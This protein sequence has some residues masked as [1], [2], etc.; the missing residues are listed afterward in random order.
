MTPVGTPLNRPRGNR[1]LL[2][3]EIGRRLRLARK[4]AH[5]SLVRAAELLEISRSMLDRIELGQ[6][7][8]SVHLAREMARLYRIDDPDDELLNLV[9]SSRIK[10]WWTQYGIANYDYIAL[11]DG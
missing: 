3:R 8:V 6:G 1:M 2:R 7:P 4:D 5:L 11:E 9:R 10:G